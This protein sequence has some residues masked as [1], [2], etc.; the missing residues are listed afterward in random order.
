MYT[1]NNKVYFDADD[2]EYAEAEVTTMISR[3]KD[4]VHLIAPY[5]GGLP[6]GVRLSNECNVPLSILDYQ[7]LDG[8]SKE[9][10]I[11][12]NVGICSN[13]ILYLVD[14]IADKGITINKCLEF[15]IQEFPNNRVIVYSILGNDEIHPP[16]WRYTYKHTG[17]WVVFGPWEGYDE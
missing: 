7:R 8:D 10:S 14:D 6:L 15:L 4:D 9:V 11:M 5:R 3:E 2:F 1:K 16:K 12:K 13:E 17:D